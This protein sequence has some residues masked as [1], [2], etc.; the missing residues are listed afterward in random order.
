MICQVSTPK[1]LSSTSEIAKCN[2]SITSV[3]FICLLA[4]VVGAFQPIIEF[5]RAVYVQV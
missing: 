2:M 3:E 5:N 1:Q 4:N